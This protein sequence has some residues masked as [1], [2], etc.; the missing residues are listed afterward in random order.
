MTYS[1]MTSYTFPTDHNSA[2][3]RRGATVREIFSHGPAEKARQHSSH[4]GEIPFPLPP[5]PG[6][7]DKRTLVFRASI[8]SME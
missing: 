7:T 6:I 8:M 1:V 5:L 4:L 2:P 3:P